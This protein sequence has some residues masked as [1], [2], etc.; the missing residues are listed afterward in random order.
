MTE[1]QPEVNPALDDLPDGDE[2]HDQHV[3]AE[4]APDDDPNIKE[5]NDG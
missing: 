4:V 1:Q 5:A 3:G 2:I